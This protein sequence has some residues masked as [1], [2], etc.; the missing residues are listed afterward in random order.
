MDT[1]SDGDRA[2][3]GALAAPF[4]LTGRVGDP[5]EVGKVVTFLVSD[6]ASVVTGADWAADGG[7]SAPGPEQTVPAIPQ[8][9]A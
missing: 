1:L 9:G 8:L 5:L 7:Y 3:I 6:D 4:H 2:I